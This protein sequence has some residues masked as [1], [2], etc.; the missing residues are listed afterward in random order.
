MKL[1]Y[2]KDGASSQVET[3]PGEEE[4]CPS[5]SWEVGR[6]DWSKVGSTPSLLLLPSSIISREGVRTEGYLI[7]LKD[8]ENLGLR[9]DRDRQEKGARNA[10][11]PSVERNRRKA[12]PGE[13]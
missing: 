3:G 8:P 12:Q 9:T 2:H 6:M 1:E 4:S 10:E 7:N 5:F 13:R 11:A